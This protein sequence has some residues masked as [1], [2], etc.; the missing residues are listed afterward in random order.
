[1]VMVPCNHEKADTRLLVH[2]VDGLK[3]GR[4]YLHS[5]RV[6]TDV[7]VIIIGNLDLISIKK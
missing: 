2:L 1:M 6:D 4:I 5:A 3:N 7:I